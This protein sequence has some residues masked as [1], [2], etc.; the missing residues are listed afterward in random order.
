MKL[1]AITTSKTA[2]AKNAKEY[3]ISEHGNYE[4]TLA[5]ARSENPRKK[6]FYHLRTEDGW[7]MWTE[8]FRV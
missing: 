6:K 4:N 2:R 8:E 1:L 3:W 7:K 5:K